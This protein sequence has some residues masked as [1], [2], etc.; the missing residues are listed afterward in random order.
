MNCYIYPNLFYIYYLL[1]II[2]YLLINTLL[3]FNNILYIYMININY[4]DIK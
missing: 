4:L 2:Y 1:F 3:S